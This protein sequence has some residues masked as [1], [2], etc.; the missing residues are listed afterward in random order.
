MSRP[1]DDFIDWTRPTAEGRVC[2]GSGFIVLGTND[3]LTCEGCD[4]CCECP[5]HDVAKL[6]AE[7]ARLEAENARLRAGR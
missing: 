4:E 7:V 5:E 6:R 1:A 3:Y 2:D